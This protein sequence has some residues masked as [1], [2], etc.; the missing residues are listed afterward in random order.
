MDNDLKT[1]FIGFTDLNFCQM[2]K[3]TEQLCQIRNKQ[4]EK[5]LVVWKTHLSHVTSLNKNQFLIPKPLIHLPCH[6]LMA[7]LDMRLFLV[8]VVKCEY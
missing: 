1:S 3:S 7:S 8:F 4:Q 6:A 5:F 2:M